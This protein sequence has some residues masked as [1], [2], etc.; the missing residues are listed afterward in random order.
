MLLLL[1]MLQLGLWLLTAAAAWWWVRSRWPRQRDAW[2]AAIGASASRP[3]EQLALRIASALEVSRLGL[4]QELTVQLAGLRVDLERLTTALEAVLAKD[5][6]TKA[7][8]TG[9]FVPSEESALA[10]ERQLQAS[11]DRAIGAG[12]TPYSPP[13]SAPSA[14]PSARGGSTRA[15]RGFGNR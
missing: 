6:Q 14:A 11:E 2:L 7:L 13:T 15:R 5:A 3:H 12:S 4:A 9:V 10:I 1:L 8:W